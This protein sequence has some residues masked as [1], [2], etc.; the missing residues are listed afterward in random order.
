MSRDTSAPAVTALVKGRQADSARRRE[1]VLKALDEAVNTGEEI[2]VR[3]EARTD[4]VVI[5]P[6][7]P[8]VTNSRNPNFSRTV[9]TASVKAVG[10]AVL[11]AKTRTATG[12][13]SESVSSPYS[14]C[15]RP[16]LPSR[17]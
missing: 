4:P 6:R 13:P 17:E 9:S 2:S 8:T 12:R 1:R 3:V 11:P 15:G 16:F 14:I 10:S 5:M 7:S